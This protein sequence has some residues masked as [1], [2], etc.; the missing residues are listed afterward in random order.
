MRID[1]AMH[2]A[3]ATP[4]TLRSPTALSQATRTRCFGG[5][6]APWR[7]RYELVLVVRVVAPNARG[8]KMETPQPS[9]NCAASAAERRAAAWPLRNQTFGSDSVDPSG[10]CS[11]SKPSRSIG[12][13]LMLRAQRVLAR[14]EIASDWYAHVFLP[15]LG[16]IHREGARRRLSR[17]NES[18]PLPLG[19]PAA[20]VS[21]SLSMV[22][23]R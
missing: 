22:A 4:A 12:Y 18:R 19:V 17:D 23:S 9:G 14:E 20:A 5:D 21:L 13:R 3:V 2:E 11:C 10:T 8:A 15:T 6:G 16:V 1:H 7:R